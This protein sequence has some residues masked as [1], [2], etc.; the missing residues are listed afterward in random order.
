MKYCN[1]ALK[2]C[3]F[4]ALYFRSIS[5]NAENGELIE[6]SP[7]FRARVYAKFD[8]TLLTDLLTDLLTKIINISENVNF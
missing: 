2:K 5:K 3:V 1:R 6:G 7:H 8:N 4:F